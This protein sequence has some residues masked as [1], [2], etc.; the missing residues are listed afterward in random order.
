LGNIFYVLLWLVGL[1]L[2]G[3]RFDILG[4]NQIIASMFE[5]GLVEFATLGQNQFILGYAWGFPEG[6]VLATFPWNGIH[7]SGELILSRLIL[8]CVAMGISILASVRFSRFDPDRKVGGISKIQNSKLE[9]L[10]IKKKEINFFN[11]ISLNPL[12]DDS[13]GFRLLPVILAEV[14]L[15]FSEIKISPLFGLV[16]FILLG[17]IGLVLPL[18]M[19]QSLFIS[20]VWVLPVL[21]WSKLG[22]RESRYRTDQLIF[23]SVNPL[24]RQFYSLWLT[25]VMVSILSGGGVALN[26]LFHGELVRLIALLVGALFIPSLAL[27]LGVWTGSS[28]FFEFLYVLLWYLGPISGFIPLDY[29]GVF[30]QSLKIGIWKN[31][32]VLTIILIGISIIGRKRQIQ[33]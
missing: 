33:T 5:A 26:L 18:D 9:D 7:Y 30:T 31:Y 16:G 1:P 2:F 4:N 22:T 29:I 13:F 14:R 8:I 28:K 21:I 3:D 23:S 12:S 25:G 20:I 19:A 32:L 17:I 6:R 24:S 11:N 10:R 27:C 15:I